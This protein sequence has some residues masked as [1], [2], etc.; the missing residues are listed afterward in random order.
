VITGEALPSNLTQIS[1]ME[2]AKSPCSIDP[3]TL[4]N[5]TLECILDLPPTCGTFKPILIS[6]NGI[7][8]NN[9][10]VTALTFDCTITLVESAQSLNLLGADNLKFTGTNFPR[11]LETNTVE[12]EFT[13]TLKTKCI[14]QKSS[15]N[16]LVCLTSGFDKI[17]SSGKSLKMNIKIN[18]IALNQDL[19]VTMKT[20]ITSGL[21][22]IPSSVNPI[23]KSKL[24]I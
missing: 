4:T 8:P 18:S 19:S 14:A 10:T 9:E 16:E 20:E 17:E 21:T 11:E 2:F 23:L 7:I 5:T 13:D 12:I 3:K 1:T 6:I 24:E 15:T 22:L